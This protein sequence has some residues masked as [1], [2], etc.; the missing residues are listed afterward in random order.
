[1]IERGA[2]VWPRRSRSLRRRARTRASGTCSS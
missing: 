1:C 2:S